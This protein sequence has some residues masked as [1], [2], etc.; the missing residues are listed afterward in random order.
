MSLE[1]RVE[2]VLKM[3]ALNYRGKDFQTLA[4]SIKEMHQACCGYEYDIK[5]GDS[6]SVLALKLNYEQMILVS[7][8]EDAEARLKLP[9][10]SENP[11][12]SITPR[13]LS[14]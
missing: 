4:Q 9:P 11:I 13:R 1:Q 10:W 14:R 6:S 3:I 2:R 8:L 12:E 5:K 7:R